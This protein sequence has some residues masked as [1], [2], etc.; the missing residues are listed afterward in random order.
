MDRLEPKK[1]HGRTYYYYSKWAWADGKC[2]RVWQKYLGKLE[3]IVKAVDQGG[4]APLYAEV[5]QWALPTAL[6]Q[7]SLTAEV[8]K[9]TDQLCPKRKQGLSTAE[10]LAIAAV[11][12]AICPSSKRSMWQWFSQTSLL[13]QI[14]HASKVSLASQRFWDHMDRI[15][16]KTASSIWKRIIKGVV[17]REDIDLSSVSY[18]G[19]N[20]YTFIDTFNTRC[21]IAKRGRNKQWR[22]NLRQISYALFCCADGHVPLF[23]DVYEGNRHDVKQFPLMLRRFHSF[24][25]ELSGNDGST[26]DTTVIFDKGNNCADNFAL[27]DSAG[28]DFVG[29][30]KLDEHKELARIPN[31][32]SAFVPCQA[33]ELEGTKALRVTKKVYSRQRTLVVTYNQ[34]LF[35]AQW[36]TLQND[37]TN[38]SE[39]LSLLRGKLQD[40]ASDL[41][42]RGKVP[43]VKSIKTQ[44]RNILSRQYL[45][46]IIKV[47]IRKAPDEVPQLNYSID[48]AALHE[49]SQT[50]LGKNILITSRDDWTDA[51]IIEAYRSQFII[52]NVFKEMKDRNTGSWWPLHHWT[53]SKIRVHG[54]YC[55]I[56]V[57]LRALM[58]RRVRKAGLELSLKRVLSELNAICEVVTIYPRK[59]RAKTERKQTTLTKTS[60]VQQQLL[61]ILGLKNEEYAVLG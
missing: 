8:L 2:R 7:E 1:I 53:D 4:P 25:K 30:V 56:A 15:D 23:Y 17:R 44:C 27:L 45:K 42:K 9:H 18:D 60:E 49:L 59:Q 28:L 20:F 31:N 13:R 41:V 36:L 52:E 58:F 24:F 12:R 61:S 39:K 16:A 43:T 34:N 32:D 19:T 37:I 48:T 55:T 40:R 21:Q 22:N 10:Y 57:L 26:P 54:L 5:F 3:N 46:D 47:T 14:P 11:N 33:A 35:N 50:W 6:W 29:S 51:K 38:A